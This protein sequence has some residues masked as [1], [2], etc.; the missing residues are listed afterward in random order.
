MPARESSVVLRAQL[1]WSITH[2]RAAAL[3]VG[4]S[5][6]RERSSWRKRGTSMR[7]PGSMGGKEANGAIVTIRQCS[8]VEWKLLSS[9]QFSYPLPLSPLRSLLCVAAPQAND[10]PRLSRQVVQAGGDA[11]QPCLGIAL[12]ARIAGVPPVQACH[13]A[14]GACRQADEKMLK[15]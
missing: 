15:K 2:T 12:P 8:D 10:S 5:G 13:T 11:R 6:T 4:R 14:L 9:V 3:R 1:V 7:L